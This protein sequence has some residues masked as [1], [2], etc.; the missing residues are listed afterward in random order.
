MSA[1]SFV[2]RPGLR[3]AAVSALVL[4]LS[5]CGA[6]ATTAAK[7]AEKFK[8]EKTEGSD[9]VRIHLEPGVADRLQLKTQPVAILAGVGAVVGTRALPYGALLYKPDGT[10]FVYTNPELDTFVHETVTVDRVNGDV[11]VI[12]AGPAQGTPVVTDGAAELMGM[13]FGVGK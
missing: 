5:G 4:A 12:S 6:V 1:L 9:V 11:A 8:V 2:R 10:T 7:P 3:S 13:E